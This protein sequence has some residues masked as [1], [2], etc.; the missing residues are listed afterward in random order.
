M[1]FL[2][3]ALN[4]SSVFTKLETLTT[5]STLVV[6]HII[7]FFMKNTIFQRAIDGDVP[8]HNVGVGIKRVA[9]KQK[10]RRVRRMRRSG[11]RATN[12]HGIFRQSQMVYNKTSQSVS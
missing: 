5:R 11:V 8:R 2:S 9:L 3:H 6:T 1:A 10:E 4:D 12:R 7:F